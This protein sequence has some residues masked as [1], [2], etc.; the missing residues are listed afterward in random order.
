MKISDLFSRVKTMDADEA[1][2]WLDR[3]PD[4]ERGL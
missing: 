1:R 3:K 4:N 2:T